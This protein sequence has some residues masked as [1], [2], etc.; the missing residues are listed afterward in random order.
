[1]DIGD[2]FGLSVGGGPDVITKVFIREEGRQE[3]Q[4]TR[5]EYRSR[6]QSEAG[7]WARKSRPPR[8]A[9]K[10]KEVGSSPESL[11]ETQPNHPS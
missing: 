10:D 3:S 7:P 2:Y 1:M 9:E 5:G 4:R 6:G 11:E 8:Q